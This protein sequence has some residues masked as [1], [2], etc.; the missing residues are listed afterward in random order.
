MN[1]REFLSASLLP[2]LAQAQDAAAPPEQ[3]PEPHFPSRLY[4]FV[5]RN[6]ELANADLMSGVVKAFAA[7]IL[8]FVT[9]MGLPKKRRLT[10]DQLARLYIS[11]IR[12]NWHVLPE[13]QIVALLG[14]VRD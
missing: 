10:E 6:C 13:S 7:K 8:D 14:W 5:W 2:G 1:R 9:S 11:V 3:I 4:Q 12:Q